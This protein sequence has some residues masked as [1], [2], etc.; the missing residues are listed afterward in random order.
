MYSIGCK[1]EDG[2]VKI[3]QARLLHVRIYK[4]LFFLE[5]FDFFTAGT[6][7]KGDAG[8]KGRLGSDSD[9]FRLH[10]NGITCLTYSGDAG[11]GIIRCQ[12]KVIDRP[13]CAAGAST[14]KDFDEA[15]LLFHHYPSGAGPEGRGHPGKNERFPGIFLNRH[16]L[17]Q[18]GG[19]L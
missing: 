9:I 1:I 3:W 6:D 18:H 13:G 17:M 16:I 11:I 8:W 4:R 12:S 10:S 14:G 5:K 19:F 15:V 7:S 2:P